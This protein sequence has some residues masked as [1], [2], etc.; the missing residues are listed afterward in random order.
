MLPGIGNLKKGANLWKRDDL[1]ILLGGRR[2][3][4]YLR[5]EKMSV[6]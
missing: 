2:R 6:L 4:S 1:E 3:P 5:C